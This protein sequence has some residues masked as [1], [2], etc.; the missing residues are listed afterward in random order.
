VESF[1]ENQIQRQASASGSTSGSTLLGAV[2]IQA[3]N[4]TVY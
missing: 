1:T 4:A 3:P 2:Q